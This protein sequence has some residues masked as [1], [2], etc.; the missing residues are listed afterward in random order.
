[1]TDGPERDRREPDR[2]R[3]VEWVDLG[4]ISQAEPAE[5]IGA[6]PRA[7]VGGLPRPPAGAVVVAVLVGLSVV[8]VL[9]R[10]GDKP[11]AASTPR[12]TATAGTTAPPDERLGPA[13]VP[14]EV[15]ARPQ[16][17]QTDP[18]LLGVKT[19]WQLFGLGDGVVVRIE[20]AAGRITTTRIPE[21]A[22]GGPVSFL[23][24][25]ESAIVRPLDEVPGYVVPD[26]ESVRGL[27]G[28][29]RSG[30]IVLP[31]PD[32]AHVWVGSGDQRRTSMVLTDL[33]GRPTGARLVIP[34]TGL[35][36]VESDGQGYVLF[37]G[38]GG[39][40]DVRPSGTQRVT[41]GTTVAVGAGR[42]LAI[43]CSDQYKCSTVVIDL[44]DGFRSVIDAGFPPTY[45]SGAISPDGRTAAV[46]E[47][48][49]DGGLGVTLYDLAYGR[50]R[51]VDIETNQSFNGDGIVWSPD[52]AWLFAV[53][54]HGNVD[55][56]DPGSGRVREL[57]V[58]L[59][60]L[61][62]LAIRPP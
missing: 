28:L 30:G 45:S 58:A 43:E 10:G 11:S 4:E 51:S 16:V 39:V 35:G 57:G 41:T 27:L 7:T 23:V 1:M 40:Y 5:V 52:S 61:S 62:Q 18:N 12:P 24:S 9:L 8:A 19:G 59:P 53:D 38:I 49:E 13:S 29:L 31:G 36:P 46:P 15:R 20:L 54:V 47:E 21:L 3:A 14:A 2:L 6:E 50:A 44:L 26:G 17:V 56:I 55:V 32:P 25:G 37:P 34:S 42:L 48:R 33:N 22:S 60:P